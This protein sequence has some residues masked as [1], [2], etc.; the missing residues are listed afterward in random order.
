MTLRHLA[1]D[2]DVADRARDRARLHAPVGGLPDAGL[3]Q[4]HAGRAPAPGQDAVRPPHRA[5][6]PGACPTTGWPSSS[7]AVDRTDGEI[8]VLAQRL[9]GVRTLAYVA[10]RPDWL[11]DAQHWQGRTRALEDRLSDTLHEKL[12]QRFIDRRTSA[13]L[14][15]GL[16]LREDVLAGVGAR[17]RGDRGGPRG[18]PAGRACASTPAEGAIAAGGPGP[19]RGRPAGG[20]PA[21]RQE[22]RRAGGG[23]RRGVRPRRGRRRA[24]ARRGG[25]PARRRRAVLAA[26]AAARRSRRR[27]GA[28]A[29]RS[30]GWRPS[31]AGAPARCCIRL[32]RLKAAVAD[33]SIRGLARGV[34]YRLMEAGGV[35]RPGRERR[36][37]RRPQPGRAARACGRW[38]CASAPSACSARRCWSRPP[39]PTPPAFAALEPAGSPRALLRPRPARRSPGHRAGGGAG[40][41]RRGRARGA[42]RAR[43]ASASPRRSCGPLDPAPGPRRRRA[44]GAGLHP[45]R[46]AGRRRGAPL[47]PPQSSPRLRG[48]RLDATVA[49]GLALPRPFPA[50]PCIGPRAKSGPKPGRQTASK[51]EPGSEGRTFR[52]HLHRS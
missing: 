14:M 31:I 43:A 35:H 20:G 24:L 2:P 26:G 10:N 37:G 19:A 47:A 9:A 52:T 33:G 23:R 36:G 12:M 4:D 7:S 32:A 8:D 45:R 15:R 11:G 48:R 34:A 22:A 1:D 21:G 46:Q 18:R 27:G 44:E 49:D 42:A 13:L 51:Q 17:R 30:G 6:S 29:G 5:A 38:A 50:R 3:P 25:R 40:A 39:A 28:R 16:N 41:V